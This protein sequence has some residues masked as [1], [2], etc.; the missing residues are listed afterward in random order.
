MEKNSISAFLFYNER[1]VGRDSVD[2]AVQ[3]E[4]ELLCAWVMHTAHIS[5]P[6]E[7]FVRLGVFVYLYV[8]CVP[9]IVLAAD[10]G[11][12]FFNALPVVELVELKGMSPKVK[13]LRAACGLRIHKVTYQLENALIV[14]VA[15]GVK[16]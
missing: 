8:I 3:L 5:R 2:L 1:F 4:P 15:G 6:H 16:P 10:F 9:D 11:A 12:Y 7:R 14:V 13:E